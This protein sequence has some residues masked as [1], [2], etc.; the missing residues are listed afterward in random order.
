[1][2]VNLNAIDNTINAY[3]CMKYAL[4]TKL[5]KSEFNDPEYKAIIRHGSIGKDGFEILYEL[6]THCHPRLMVATSKV[7]HQSTTVTGR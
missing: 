3:N 6:M 7:N 2:L 4:Y 5:N 1:M